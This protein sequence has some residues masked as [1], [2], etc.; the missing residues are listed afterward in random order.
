MHYIK[1]S[2]HSNI[3]LCG[4]TDATA[5][6]CDG[7][8]AS[9]SM[10]NGTTSPDCDIVTADGKCNNTGYT[11]I[12]Q[13]CITEN[14]GNDVDTAIRTTPPISTAQFVL[15]VQ[16]VNC[17]FQHNPTY[18]QFLQANNL[19]CHQLPNILFLCS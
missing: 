15:P 6:T 4:V 1:V 11:R 3:T 13:C 10:M 2:I 17:K 19:G 7:D 9:A 16:P 5:D 12:T 18:V 14:V 8:N